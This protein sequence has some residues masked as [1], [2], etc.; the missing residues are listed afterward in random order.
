MN[1]DRPAPALAAKSLT[2]RE[3]VRG[4]TALSLGGL[5]SGLGGVSDHGQRGR[6]GRQLHD[7]FG[8]G[9]FP[10]LHVALEKGAQVVVN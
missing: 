6:I 8:I 1:D 3:F 4:T 2:R 10:H 7:G 5:A 9:R